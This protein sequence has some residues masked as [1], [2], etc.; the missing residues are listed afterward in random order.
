MENETDKNIDARAERAAAYKLSGKY[1]CAQ[2]VACA[3]SG[4]VNMDA[5]TLGRITSAFG[6]GFGCTRGTCGALV[7]AGVILGL[8]I[9]DR[10][11][12]RAE[13]KE[14][15]D[16]F[17]AKNGATICRQL[18]GIDTGKPLRSCEGCVADAAT[19]LSATLTEL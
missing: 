2:S 7:G 8:K 14:M 9:G 11:K 16:K 6:T 10:V 18:K 3:F 4:D 5:D 13:M 15:M 1:N 12:A 19:L 17:E